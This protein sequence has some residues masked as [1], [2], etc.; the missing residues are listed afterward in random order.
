MAVYNGAAFVVPQIDSILRQ[1][2]SGD[3]LI[4]V[5][6]ASHDRS[7]ALLRGIGDPRLHVHCNE[8]NTGV[9]RAFEKALRLARGEIVFLS[10]QDDVWLEG[11]IDKMLA[12][13]Q[14]RPEVTMVLSD[15][16]LIDEAGRVI[17]ESYFSLRGRFAAGLVRNFV[18]NKYLGCTLS[19][20]RS[21]LKRFLPIPEDVPMHD[22]WFGALNEIYGRTHFI[23]EPLVAYRRHPRNASPLV[24]RGMGQ[25]LRWRWRLAKNL[26]LRVM[27]ARASGPEQGT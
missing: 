16:R 10:D 25:I 3:E 1:L 12:V 2:R 7:Q 23:D 15:A 4:V 26:A 13:Y 14:A 8:A 9:L 19:F 21:M 20:R 6:D 22:I 27:R 17:S 5:D 18:K 24:R 11:K